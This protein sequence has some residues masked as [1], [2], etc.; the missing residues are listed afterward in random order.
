MSDFS[1]QSIFGPLDNHSSLPEG[2]WDPSGNEADPGVALAQGIVGAVQK[3]INAA[4]GEKYA[5]GQLVQ[6]RTMTGTA[7]NTSNQPLFGLLLVGLIVYA[8]ARA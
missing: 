8:V 1:I 3:A 7:F 6:P 4:V 2:S 5:D